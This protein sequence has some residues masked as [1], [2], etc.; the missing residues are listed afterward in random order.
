MVSTYISVIASLFI[1][2]VLLSIDNALVN[3]TLAEA[4]PEEKRVKAIR[5]G[6]ILGAVFRFVALFAVTVIIHNLWLKILGALYLIYLAI[7]HLGKVIDESGHAHPTKTTFR[8]VVTQIALADIVFS[9]DNVI[10][11]VSFSSNT[12][13]VMFGVLVGVI[14]MLFI[15]PV[16]SRLIH[17]YKGMPQAA[18]AIVGLIG[19]SLFL[20]TVFEIHITEFT[21][22]MAILCIIGFTVWYEHSLSLQKISN[23]VLKK[24]QYIIAIPL[25]LVYATKNLIKVIAKK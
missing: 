21:K 15:T 24:M 9:I 17:R 3:A 19:I 25:D 13:L 4:L 11:A 1:I 7:E 14:S 8:G 5:L 2:E 18:Y 10:S 6:I 16:L 20:E 22:F 23:P 12:Y